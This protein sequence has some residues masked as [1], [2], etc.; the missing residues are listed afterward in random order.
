MRHSYLHKIFAILQLV[1]Y[2][3]TGVFGELFH[4]HHQVGSHEY[5]WFSEDTGCGV[6]HHHTT[7][8]ISEC[9][10]CVR[11]SN[12]Q[13]VSPSLILQCFTETEYVSL[14]RSLNLLPSFSSLTDSRGPPQA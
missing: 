14:E 8:Q 5:D 13:S 11:A 1:F 4:S 3:G 10:A 9:L 2:F 6:T 7:Y 12:P